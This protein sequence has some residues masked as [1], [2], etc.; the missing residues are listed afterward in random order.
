MA[1]SPNKKM[2]QTAKVQ[3]EKREKK[4]REEELADNELLRMIAEDDENRN[5]DVPT[6]PPIN[7]GGELV[8]EGREA[9]KEGD[10]D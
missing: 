1:M 2:L 3:K 10:E 6:L 5:S 7:E 9:G 4:E 8:T